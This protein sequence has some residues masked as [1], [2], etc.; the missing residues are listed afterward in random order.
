MLAGIVWAA[1][2]APVSAAVLV[3]CGPQAPS[4][5]GMR[6]CAVQLLPGDLVITEVFADEKLTAGGAG[7]DAGK[8]WLEIYN[9]RG[10]A[11]DLG[12]VT[13]THSRPGGERPSSHTIRDATI[14]PGQFFVLGNA[15]PAAVPAYVD[16]GYGADLGEL[17]NTGG[18]KL[19]LSCGD[20][21]I[22][23][24]IYDSVREGR[25]R[26]LTSAQPPEY[27]LNDDPSRWCQA[28]ATEFEAGNFGTPG[29]ANDCQPIVIGQCNDRGTMRDAV[30]PGPGDLVITEVMP[31]PERVGDT[32][33]E[34]FEARAESDVDLNGVGLERAGDS[35]GPDVIT[36]ADCVHL[37]AGSY[38]VFVRS[39]VAAD[40]GGIPAAVIAARFKFAMVAGAPAA[41]G[42]VA[43]VAGST[44]VDAVTWTKSSAGKALQLAPDRI[45][46]IANDIESNFCAA[47]AAYGAGDLGTP[48]AANSPCVLPSSGMCDDGGTSRAIVMPEPGQLVISE[49]LA[50]PAKPLPGNPASDAQREWFEVA[51]I[52]ATAFDLNELVVGRIGAAGAPVQSATCIA[53]P[54]GGFAVLARSSDPVANGMLPFV[55]AT[56][57]FALVDIAGDLQIAAG[58]TVL[59]AVTWAA[60]TSGATLQLDPAHL[61]PT[62]NDDP[63]QFCAGSTPYGDATNQG[64][65][66]TVNLP[67]P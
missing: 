14:A 47:T 43:I 24:A 32:V 65:P 52:A 33:G 39:D 45:D 58:A 41:P 10:A 62:D 8:E 34:W 53:V 36:A 46:A 18:G 55:D 5:R 40:N 44:V 51:N 37:T 50:N 19:V 48:G 38:A 25:S 64:T 56:F 66:G 20:V 31:S 6:D 4:E 17:Y 61:R 59:D 54:P 49:I 16:H 12:G 28:S 57:R 1:L 27:T 67:C 21:E 7:T 26:E 23:S 35:A 13:I 11:V 29:A 60:V 2:A 30:A 15:A 22:D 3:G 9:A 63:A 42:D